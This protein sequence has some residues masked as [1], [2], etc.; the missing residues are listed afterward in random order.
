MRS[1]SISAQE[2]AEGILDCVAERAAVAAWTHV[3]PERVLAQARA[4]DSLDVHTLP[5]A[6]LPVGIKDLMDTFDQPTSYG[7]PI[8]KGHRPAADAAIVASLRALGAVVIGKTVTT[9]FAYRHAGPTVNPHD[10]G[11][12]P[13]GSSSGSAA[14]VADHQIPIG[15]ATQ[16]SGSI[17][18]PAAF[19]G[20]VGFKP[21]YGVLPTAGVRPCAES[22]DTVGF[23]GRNV[24]DICLIRNALVGRVVEAQERKTRPKVALCRTPM[25]ALASPAMVERLDT[26]AGQLKL[27][28]AQ[29]TEV[30]FPEV[31]V[32]T[33][34]WDTQ[35]I[36]LLYEMG[37]N[38]ANE[39]RRHHKLL[40]AEMLEALQAARK[41]DLDAYRNA[42][43][44]AQ[45]CRLAMDSLLAEHDFLLTFATP[46]EAPADLD[47][48]GDPVFN[49]AWT[50]LH[51]PCL[52]LPSG[53][54]PAGLPLGV[55][56]V[57]ARQ[58]DESL[59]Q[60]GTWAEAAL[61]ALAS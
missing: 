38:L 39:F 26:A 2:V 3:D 55:Q 29:V 52:T 42:Q 36:T 31:C 27:V 49:A 40:S 33:C 11:H 30:E 15:T 1:G 5:L 22:L 16:T 41:I 10:S 21:T 43:A 28:G 19:C 59:L 54:S 46:G 13:G 60:W 45:R 4:I 14:A 35:H 20:V 48:T 8:Y 7:S 9:E 32:E 37:R 44:H 23:I 58:Q 25:A 6:G 50:L 18:R 12:T 51:V 57:G 24:G 34:L 61:R 47:F 53:N 17:I 56:L